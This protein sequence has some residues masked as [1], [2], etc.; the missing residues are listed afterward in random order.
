MIA[1]VIIS[2]DNL[3]IGQECTLTAKGVY[4]P[5]SDE[6]NDA[7]FEDDG[8]EIDVAV[9]LRSVGGNVELGSSDDL[10]IG[11][12]IDIDF[13]SPGTGT[14][15]VDA[16]DTV[17][18]NKTFENYLKS[19]GS[20]IKRIEAVSRI[21]QT[22]TTQIEQDKF[23]HGDNPDAVLKL[24]KNFGFFPHSAYV[25]RGEDGGQLDLAW[26]LAFTDSVSL[27]VPTLL[28]PEDQGEVEIVQ[29]ET[30]ELELGDHPELARAYWHK[31]PPP[32]IYT[33]NTDLNLDK[34]ARKLNRLVPILL[35]KN[36]VATLDRIV[37]EIYK[38]AAQPPN[39]EQEVLIAQRIELSQAKPWIA[40]LMEYTDVLKTMVGWSHEKTFREVV[41]AFVTPLF[42]EN[43]LHE[44][45][46]AYVAGK[47][48]GSGS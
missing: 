32:E 37:F 45:S 19:A 1:I 27:A 40:A 33:L 42:E 43:V 15:V 11:P 13:T 17:T 21:T 41:S 31:A 7:I 39:P 30:E 18:F 36:I 48:K 23:P 25:L 3:K 22:L 28:E 2:E 4:D 10:P 12:V 26:V 8:S 46:Y 34:A 14:L 47:I 38:D 9:Y 29:E 20:T 24:W 35:D 5:T 16:L 6:R 44:S